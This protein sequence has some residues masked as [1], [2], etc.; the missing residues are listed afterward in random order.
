MVCVGLS[1]CVGNEPRWQPTRGPQGGT[2]CCTHQEDDVSVLVEGSGHADALALTTGQVD[3]LPPKGRKGHALT[4]LQ[5]RL[6]W[7]LLVS[8]LGGRPGSMHLFA[9]SSPG[10]EGE[11]VHV[12]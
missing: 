6:S 11:L 10:R 9:P 3:A 2:S 1:I 4:A 7:P 12:Y 8:S 5:E